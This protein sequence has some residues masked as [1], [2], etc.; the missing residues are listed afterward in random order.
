MK[1]HDQFNGN[2]LKTYSDCQSFLFFKSVKNASSASYPHC[3]LHMIVIFFIPQSIVVLFLLAPVSAITNQPLWWKPA[4]LIKK[5]Y[6]IL[7]DRIV[8]DSAVQNSGT[9]KTSLDYSRP[10]QAYPITLKRRNLRLFRGSGMTKHIRWERT[11]AKQCFRR[12]SHAPVKVAGI[13]FFH[14][15]EMETP[16]FITIAKDALSNWTV[17]KIWREGTLTLAIWTSGCGF[18]N[19]LVKAALSGWTVSKDLWSE[20]W[21]G[22]QNGILNADLLIILL[23]NLSQE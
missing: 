2:L 13:A 20:S 16:A 10:R 12:K 1:S 6:P 5:R 9:H 7:Q 22:K 11:L 17:S 18:N 4:R 23:K 21:Y 3:L 14:G 8:L 19:H 15:A